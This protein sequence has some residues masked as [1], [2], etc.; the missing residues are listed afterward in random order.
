MITRPRWK[1]S[2]TRASSRR[3]FFRAGR[4]GA[5]SWWQRIHGY[6]YARWPY[7]YIGAAIGKKRAHKALRLL[8]WPW[9]VKALW[10]KRWAAGYHGKVLPT[11]EAVKLVHIQEPVMAALP[12]QV[13]P[14]ATARD[15][16]L[17]E[18]DHLV[19]LDCPCR[20]SRENPCLPLD[21]CL[22]VGEPFASFVLSH[23][24]EHARAISPEEAE[25]ILR[26]EAG[27]GH[28]H[29]A[30]FKEGMLGRFYAICNC[31]SCCCGAMQAQQHGTPMLISS[32]YVAEVE[33]ALC[34][35]CGTCARV[36]PFGAI[37]F[38]EQPI[39]DRAVCMGCG[40]C[41]NHCPAGA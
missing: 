33:A 30:F 15:L 1:A 16:I 5:V 11:P 35:G 41:V 13:I 23:H 27:R 36:C 24:P 25:G 2:V 8:F 37:T 32:G 9:L 19:V 4:E 18:P 29:H 17:Q 34:Q 21:V 12:E 31:C 3:A 22:I 28:V 26:A 6:V 7:G 38:D 20:L 14:F 40:V 10:P 39:V